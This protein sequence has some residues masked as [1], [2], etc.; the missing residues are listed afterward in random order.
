VSFRA[1]VGS[2][3]EVEMEVALSPRKAR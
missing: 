1:V 3:D 2:G